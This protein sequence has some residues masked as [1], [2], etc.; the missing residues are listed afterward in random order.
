[1]PNDGNPSKRDRVLADTGWGIKPDDQPANAAEAGADATNVYRYDTARNE[2]D[3]VRRILLA[4]RKGFNTANGVRV[5]RDATI[6]IDINGDGF[7]V[8]GLTF[9]DE[10]LVDLLQR[11][12]AAFSPP[13]LRKL[14]AET[15]T[16][17]EFALSRAWAW[18][19]ERSGG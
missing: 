12:G 13:E 17:R 6:I 19:A 8:H 7:R 10:N 5:E 15:D 9:G 2:P 4:Q 16:P 11:L 14:L 3:V 18:G 1:M